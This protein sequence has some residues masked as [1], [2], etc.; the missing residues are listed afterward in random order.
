MALSGPHGTILNLNK[1]YTERK[2]S[3]GETVEVKA[4]GVYVFARAN[5]AVLQGDLC[6]IDPETW[7]ADSVTTTESGSTG[8]MCGIAQAALADN[9]FGWFWRGCGTTEAL[10]AD[11]VSADTNGTTTANAGVIGSGGDAIAT[12]TVIDANSSGAAALRTVKAYGFIGTN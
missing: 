7:D 1:A 2:F 11:G 12:L 5:G 10:V 6:K 9:E 3:L 4:K 8:K